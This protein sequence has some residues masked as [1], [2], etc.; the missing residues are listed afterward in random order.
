MTAKFHPFSSTENN[1]EF[2][3]CFY[4]GEGKKKGEESF[5]LVFSGFRKRKVLQITSGIGRREKEKLCF[6]HFS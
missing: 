4:A 6:E 2:A 5:L 1:S 3:N